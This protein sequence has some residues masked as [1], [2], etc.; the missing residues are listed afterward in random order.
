MKLE[1]IHTAS[2]AESHPA[3]IRL[4][5]W[6]GYVLLLLSLIDLT[7]IVIPFNFSNASWE[8]QTIGAV[9][10]RIPLPLLGI[11]FIFFGGQ[12]LRSPLERGVVWLLSWLCLP[13]AVLLLLL[14]PLALGNTVRI[15]QQTTAQLSSQYAQQ[16][17]QIDQFESQISQATADDI[18][19]FLQAQGVELDSAT[20]PRDQAVQEI[21]QVRQQLYTN[22]EQGKTTQR[23]NLLKGSIKWSMGALIS[24]FFLVY[25]WRLTRWTRTT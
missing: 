6:T 19:N 13:A 7:A 21:K 18:Q 4:V 2:L 25:I 10:E 1:D 15:N 3:T 12:I 24:S 17:E 14:A 23:T 22:Y 9:V 5:R 20:V 11:V 16:M 8:L